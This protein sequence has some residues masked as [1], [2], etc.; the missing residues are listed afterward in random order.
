MERLNISE[1]AISIEFTRQKLFAT[2]AM[3]V[4]IDAK[5]PIPLCKLMIKSPNYVN[6]TGKIPHHSFAW[7][8][9]PNSSSASASAYSSSRCF[10]YAL[11]VGG[12]FIFRLIAECQHS[13]PS[14]SPITKAK[15]HVGVRSSFSIVKGSTI[16]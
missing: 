3:L 15:T 12:R 16:K 4:V 7:T 10:L 1:I 6:D 14:A 13:A 11:A 5:R 9:L 2:L 8:F